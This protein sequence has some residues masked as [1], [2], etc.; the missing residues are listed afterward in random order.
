MPANAS[1]PPRITAISVGNVRAGQSGR[2]RIVL[3]CAQHEALLGSVGPTLHSAAVTEAAAEQTATASRRCG[4]PLPIR[5]GARICARP[6][7]AVLGRGLD[8]IGLFFMSPAVECINKGSE[9]IKL[10]CPTVMDPQEVDL[11]S[12]N[13]EKFFN[14]LGCFYGIFWIF[15]Y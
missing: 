15:V 13:K 4:A 7:S 12:K 14:C 2:E 9:N 8:V 10:K 6:S 3:D 1:G 5:C 11:M